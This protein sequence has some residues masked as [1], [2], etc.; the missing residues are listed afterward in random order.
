MEIVWRGY[1]L[2]PDEG[3][4]PGPAAVEAM[5]GWWGDRATARIARIQ[6]LGPRRA[7]S[8]ACVW[9][10]SADG[11]RRDPVAPAEPAFD[12][13]AERDRYLPVGARKS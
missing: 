7:W 2:A 10:E 11:L 1:E 5:A 8:S 4:I 12:Q 13:L 9:V 3:R 6:S